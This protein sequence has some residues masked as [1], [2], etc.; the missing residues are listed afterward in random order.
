MRYT[1]L[2]VQNLLDNARKYGR[3]RES[4]RVTA[5]VQPD[6]VILVVANRGDA[7]PPA[8]WEPI[9]ERFHRAAVGERIAGHG[10]GL[11]LARDLARLHGGDVRLVRSDG[12]WTEFEAHFTPADAP[13]RKLTAA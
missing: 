1:M 13:A 9:F 12:E 11:N 8:S 6:S 2:I 10:L 5:R 7:I 3:A 4:I